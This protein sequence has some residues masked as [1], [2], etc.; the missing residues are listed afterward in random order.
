ATQ[1]LA[2]VTV[3][4]D[5]RQLEAGAA[6]A[7]VALPALDIDDRANADPAALPLGRASAEGG[8]AA[9]DAF[10]RAL[11]RARDGAL[12]AIVFAPFNKQALRLGGMHHEDELRFAADFLGHRG[13]HGEF[14]VLER[15]WNARVTSHVPLG[16]VAARL[17][18]ARIVEAVALT[19]RAMREAG[20]ATPRIA[21][22]A[23]NPHAGDGGSYGREEIEVIAP[24]V[25]AARARGLEASGPYPAD[26]V[27]L[28]A[29][30]GAF[31]AVVTM[32]HDQGQIAIKLLGFER[33]VT[34]LGGLP[35]PI[36]TPAHGSAY[37]IAGRG[38][39]NDRALKRA[40]EIAVDM[41]RARCSAANDD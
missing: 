35:I 39:A 4:G 19:D 16:E 15:L 25:E 29:R 27:W 12:D 30:D 40:F 11:E 5:A 20:F 6:I 18:V 22:A 41:A 24:A 8:R 33:G 14:N 26:T 9:L 1:A 28:R 3:I 10:R 23:L 2:A 13:A 21:V 37:D 32:Y 31:D 34:V 36:T 7:R 38:V 17:S